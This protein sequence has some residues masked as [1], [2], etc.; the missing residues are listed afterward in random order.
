MAALQ[1]HK[2]RARRCHQPCPLHLPEELSCLGPLPNVIPRQTMQ[3]FAVLCIETSHY[4]AFARH[5]PDVHQWLFF[6]SMADREGKAS[7]AYRLFKRQSRPLPVVRGKCD[8]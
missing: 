5:G 2:H 1:V 3:L 8:P 4:V 6:D 7:I